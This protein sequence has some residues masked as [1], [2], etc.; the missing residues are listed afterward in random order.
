LDGAVT[1]APLFEQTLSDLLLGARKGVQRA[2]ARAALAARRAAEQADEVRQQARVEVIRAERRAAESV[3]RAQQDA[4]AQVAEARRDAEQLVRQERIRRALLAEQV[5]EQ[6]RSTLVAVPP[7]PPL[8]G[9]VGEP[10]DGPEEEIEPEAP[11]VP[12]MAELL[13]PSPGVTRFLD[14]L[15]GPAVP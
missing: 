11:P 5:E 1:D 4:S 6:V 14:A 7:L 3:L 15:L 8:T 9:R 12:S 13:K 2:E 10:V